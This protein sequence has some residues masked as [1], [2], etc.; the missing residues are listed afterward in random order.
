M[1]ELNL[2]ISIITLNVN[3]LNIVIKRWIL[4]DWFFFKQGPV[5]LFIRGIPKICR[6]DWR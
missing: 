1:V 3:E 2:I 4:S 6:R 5:M